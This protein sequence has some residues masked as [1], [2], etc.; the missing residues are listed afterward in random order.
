MV[1]CAASGL[2]VSEGKTEIMCL[3]TKE[4]S[5]ST[6]IFSVE[7]ADQVYNQTEEFVHLGG[8]VNHNADLSI[9]VNW[10]IRNAWGSFR[11]YTLELYDRPSALLELKLRMLIA[12]VLET[13]SYGCV[14]SSPLADHYDTLRRA[15]HSFL[16][17]CIGWLMNYRADHPTPFYQDTLI[18]KTGSESI[19]ATLRRKRILFAGFVARIEDT[20]LKER[21]LLFEELVGDA[22]CAGGQKKEWIGCSLNDI[23]AF[24]INADQWMIAAQDDGK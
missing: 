23:G 20:R 16:T 7:A 18:I 1:V 17:C 4:M 22:G 13:M 12:E 21:V 19:E 11:K 5:E 10:R 9:K 2:T 15:H 8:D 6:V 24:G 3:R 14:T